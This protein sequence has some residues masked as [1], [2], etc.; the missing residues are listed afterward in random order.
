[1]KVTA[2][3]AHQLREPDSGRT[4]ALLK[5]STAEGISGW[6]EC[7]AISRSSLARAREL[8]IGQEESRY[9]YLTRQ[10]AG[11]P[12]SAALNMALL[13]L[14]GKRSNVPVFQLLG[15]P[16]RNRVRALTYLDNDAALEGLL[17]LGHRAFLVP[18]ELPRSITSRPRQINAVVRRF[19]ALRE[20]AGEKVDFAAD[21]QGRLPAAEANDLAVALEPLHPLWL[22]QPCADT[23]SAILERI[24]AEST[25]P[26][27]LGTDLNEIG[28]VQHLLR[29]SLVDVVRLPISKWGITPLRRAA[30]IAETYYV[31]VAP[32]H[33]AGGPVATAAALHLAA[34]LPNFFIQQLPAL[35]NA[36]ERKL[37]QDLVGANLETVK[38]G[39]LSLGA[40][41]GLGLNIDESIVRRLSQ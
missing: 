39:S 16:T 11:D 19:A 29:D 18:F 3:D 27:G 21:G 13:D 2:L 1:M 23:N 7:V 35:T 26:L 4:Y 10:F 25:V 32:Y 31:A 37:R 30:A 38:D 34:S 22:E 12:F 6:G 28:P 20:A 24:S 8:V 41:P 40:A 9:D 33:K 5:V 17:A 15:G 36:D 14:A